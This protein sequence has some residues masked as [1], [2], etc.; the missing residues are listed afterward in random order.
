VGT[1]VPLHC[2]C[3][4]FTSSLYNPCAGCVQNMDQRATCTWNEAV[5]VGADKQLEFKVTAN[6]AGVFQN[7]ATVFTTMPGVSNVSTTAPVTVVVRLVLSGEND[8]YKLP[9]GC[10]HH[11][12]YTSYHLKRSRRQ[13]CEH[14]SVMCCTA[15]AS[16]ACSQCTCMAASAGAC[17]CSI[18]TACECPVQR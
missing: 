2:N 9:C 14:G 16:T 11:L 6:K 17:V 12:R 5:T 3:Y 8:H 10:S 7:R 4:S 18:C 15:Q 13:Y 1:R